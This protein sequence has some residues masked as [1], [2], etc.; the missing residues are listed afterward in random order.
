M[1]ERLKVKRAPRLPSPP[2]STSIFYFLFFARLSF[3][4]ARSRS[5]FETKHSTPLANRTLPSPLP[6]AFYF[7]E[8]PINSLL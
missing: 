5:R 3:R 2:R 7:A 1:G 4:F 8:T 6:T